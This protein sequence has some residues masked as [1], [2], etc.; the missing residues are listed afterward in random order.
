[1]T[2][3]SAA[4]TRICFSA[5]LC[6]SPLPAPAQENF[7]S[8]FNGHDL[9]GWDTWLGAPEVPAMPI[10]LW[11]EWPAQI[12]LNHDED[13]IFSV[14]TED[15]EPAIRISGETWGALTSQEEYANYHLSLKY[16]W[17]E[18][19]FAPRA[20]KPRNSGLLYHATGQQGAFWTYWMRSVE[21]EIMQG[22]TG[23]F[24]S[25]DGVTGEIA[26]H[27][28]WNAPVPWQRYMH[29][30]SALSVGGM[31]FRVSA[32]EDFEHARGEWNTLDLHVLGDSSVHQVNGHTV[33][34][35]DNL[36]HEKDGHSVPLDK[37]KIQFQSEGAE[38]Y[39]RDIRIEDIDTLPA[40]D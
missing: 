1:M 7:Q 6:M 30:A 19:R 4:L 32:A 15:G 22:A 37:G 36:A 28:D 20:E 8:L 5:A 14:V 38:I 33:M 40:N 2:L 23:D 16:K 35:I 21:F 17:G 31:I 18:A 24:T 10:K 39:F 34:R 26:T 25:V 11:G 12:G 13:G 9:S 27:W 29:N 3:K